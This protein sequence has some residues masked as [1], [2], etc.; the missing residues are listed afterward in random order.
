MLAE[1]VANEKA[2]SVCLLV[3]APGIYGL[4][5]NFTSPTK[6]NSTSYDALKTRLLVH[7]WP[8]SDSGKIMVS[9]QLWVF[10]RVSG[11]KI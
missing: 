8:H 9:W 10:A 3:V 5:R 2:V 1:D 4:W 7:C 6:L 11:V